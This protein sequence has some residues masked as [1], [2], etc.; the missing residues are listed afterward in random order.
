MRPTQPHRRHGA[1]ATAARVVAA[2]I[3]IAT[4]VLI[5]PTAAAPA[6][7]D[8]GAAAAVASL[9]HRLAELTEE[10]AA[11]R[12]E[13]GAS[14]AT[15]TPAQPTPVAQ[16]LPLAATDVK[17]FS[18]VVKSGL[19]VNTTGE[20]TCYELNATGVVTHVWFTIGTPM[21][22]RLRFYIDGESTPSIDIMAMEGLASIGYDDDTNPWGTEL[23]GKGASQGAVW[24]TRRIPFGSSLKVTAT[25]EDIPAGKG[26]QSFFFIIHGLEAVNPATWPGVQVAGL[27]LPPTAR[28]KLHKTD[29]QALGALEYLTIANVTAGRGGLVHEVVMQAN[30]STFLYLEACMRA[31]IDGASEPLFLSSG[32]EDFFSSANYFDGSNGGT[33]RL[34]NSGLTYKNDTLHAMSAY[35]V[36]ERDPLVF[37]DGL[38]LVWRNSENPLECPFMWPWHPKSAP[39]AVKA[40]KAQVEGAPLLPVAASFLVWVYEW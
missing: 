24:S 16:S 33:F 20:V 36:M 2:A 25:I 29:V 32:T 8:A 17:T 30:A 9:E 19:A 3:T 22:A 5:A 37:H 34:P 12:A 11:L 40:V 31:Y 21:H 10:L 35:R 15:S 39:E 26:I 27:Q 18:G 7:A 6:A 1:V 14:N 4:L 23:M 38:Q 13:I 28:L